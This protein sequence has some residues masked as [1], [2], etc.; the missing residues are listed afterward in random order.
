MGTQVEAQRVS[1]GIGDGLA[2][3]TRSDQLRNEYV[4]M[5][6]TEWS[7]PLLSTTR[8]APFTVSDRQL[9]ASLYFRLAVAF[10]LHDAPPRIEWWPICVRIRRAGQVSSYICQG[11]SFA[12]GK[13]IV[14]LTYHT[15]YQWKVF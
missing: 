2:H 8:W 6:T 9:L 10:R 1:I 7:H 12:S 15:F 13:Q 11:T 3:G 14:F 4:P 5:S